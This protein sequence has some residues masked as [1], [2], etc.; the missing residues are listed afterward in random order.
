MA[1]YRS[2][3]ADAHSRQLILLRLSWSRSQGVFAGVALEGAT[4]RQDLDDNA[5]LHDKP[6]QNRDT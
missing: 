5:T 3:R 2:A 4:L 1:P 6:R